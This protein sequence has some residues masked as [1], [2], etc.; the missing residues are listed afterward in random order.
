MNRGIVTKVRVAL[1]TNCPTGVRDY[2]QTL[3][4]NHCFG[5]KNQVIILVEYAVL[6]AAL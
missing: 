6:L 3:N 4:T 2:T 5:P 1:K